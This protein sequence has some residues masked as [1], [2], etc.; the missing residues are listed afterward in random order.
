MVNDLEYYG[1]SMI[2]GWWYTYP[3]EKY[4]SQLGSWFPTEWKNK[5]HEI[6]YTPVW[7]DVKFTGG[8]HISYHRDIEGRNWISKE[9]SVWWEIFSHF[10]T[11]LLNDVP[12]QNTAVFHHNSWFFIS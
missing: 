11:S 9:E 3:S 12:K 2:T 7:D 1:L 4:E 5:S 10:F 6:G 8:Y